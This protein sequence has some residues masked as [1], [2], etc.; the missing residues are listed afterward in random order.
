MAQLTYKQLMSNLNESFKNMSE[1]AW[2]EIPKEDLLV[3]ENAY[4]GLKELLTKSRGV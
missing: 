3:Y 1:I 4:Q 2:V